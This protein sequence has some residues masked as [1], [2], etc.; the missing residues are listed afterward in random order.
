VS[1]AVVSTALAAGLCICDPRPSVS[2]AGSQTRDRRWSRAGSSTSRCAWT[3]WPRCASSAS[4]AGWSFRCSI[5]P[6]STVASL[7]SGKRRWECRAELALKDP[8]RQPSDL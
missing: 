2:L 5:P 3:Q 4:G 6:S 7:Y 8:N 1:I